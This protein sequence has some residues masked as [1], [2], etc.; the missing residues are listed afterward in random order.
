M[1]P[2]TFFLSLLFFSC[3]ELERNPA[4]SF[5]YDLTMPERVYKMPKPLKE[6]SGISLLSESIM[7]CIEDNHGI[8]YLYDLKKGKI[9]KQIRFDEKGDYED[10][11]E[12]DNNFYVLRSDGVIFKIFANNTEFYQTPLNSENNTEGL[13]LDKKKNCLLIACKDD[14]GAHIS[15]DNKSVYK[16]SLSSHMLQVQPSFSISIDDIGLSNAK[17]FSPSGI[18]I[19]PQSENIFIISSRGNILVE[20]DNTGKILHAEK[21]DGK[22]FMQPEGICFS[23]EGDLFISNEGQG[24]EHGTILKFKQK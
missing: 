17:D 10:I 9:T 23:P 13:C 3:T 6:I 20:A 5:G 24:H 21:L 12:A 16:F 1:Q 7:A 8:I 19:H 15:K 2:I 22:F 18:A 14:P 4:N 11:A